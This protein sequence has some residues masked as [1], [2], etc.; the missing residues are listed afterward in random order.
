MS[1]DLTD[2]SLKPVLSKSDAPLRIGF[3]TDTYLPMVNGVAV[4]LDLLVR[5]L[6]TAG[7]QVTIVA[8][9]FPG[10][11][12]NDLD[13]QRIP[14]IKYLQRP[15]LYMAV[16]GTPR[17]ILAIR[18]CQFDVLHVHS[19]FSVGLLAYFAARAKHIPL[20]YTNHLSVMDYTH[21]LKIGWQTRPVQ[22]AARWFSH[23]SANLSDQI[24]VPSKKFDRLLREQKVHRP[25]H[26][27]PNG[28][29]L[30]NF[31]RASQPGLFR[32]QL[33]LGADQR[34]LLFVGR[35]DP[36]K[37]IDLVIDMFA[38][39]AAQYT[40]IHLVIAG[41]GGARPKLEIQAQ[42]CGYGDRIH[43]L[44]MVNRSNLPNLLHEAD[45]FVSAS[46]SETQCLA[47]VEAIAA[48]LPV[49]A[50]WDEAFE[51]ILVDGV[52]G[53]AAPRDVEAFCAIVRKLLDDPGQCKIFGQKS[54]EL[55]R[56]FSIEAQVQA[57]VELYRHAIANQA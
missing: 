12:D 36:E 5:G 8:P 50:V 13:V 20:I 44:G 30:A 42:T 9:D 16:P 47:M 45:L 48:G 35:V 33:G 40:D 52:N 24:I 15:P 18:R 26:V 21:Y 17:A 1:Y 23:A 51:D 2:T 37:R 32:Q 29:D 10:Y 38:R 54:M 56:K 7:H 31:Y 43:F 19:P 49:A 34:M 41:D 6:R 4:S 14:S 46:T 28:I 53:Y 55:S 3:F 27:I 39:L 22:S 11:S 57:L 25:I